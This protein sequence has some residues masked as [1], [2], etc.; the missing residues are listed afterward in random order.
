MFLSSGKQFQKVVLGLLKKFKKEKLFR[1]SNKN[2]FDVAFSFLPLFK[3]K[4]SFDVDKTLVGWSNGLTL[5]SLF[6]LKL[7]LVGGALHS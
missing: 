3:T 2:L 5:T 7:G 4:N 1:V 6:G